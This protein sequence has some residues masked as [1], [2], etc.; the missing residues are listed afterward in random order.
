MITLGIDVMEGGIIILTA[1]SKS[2][3][4]SEMI[5]AQLLDKS[6]HGRAHYCIKVPKPIASRFVKPAVDGFFSVHRK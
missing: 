1:N 2:W 3:S 5:S 6:L 4:H